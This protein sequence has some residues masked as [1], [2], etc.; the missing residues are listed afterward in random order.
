MEGVARMGGACGTS[1]LLQV[2]LDAL[3][4]LA[5]THLANGLTVCRQSHSLLM[6]ITDGRLMDS[7]R[8]SYSISH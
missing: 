5:S 7:K 2:G 4:R 1:C 8:V 3:A 6:P